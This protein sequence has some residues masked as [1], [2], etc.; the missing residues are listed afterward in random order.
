MSDNTAITGL[1]VLSPTECLSRLGT[2]GIGRVGFV[3]GGRPQVLPVNYTIVDD[4]VVFRTSQHSILTRIAG[5]PVTFEVDGFD[6]ENR[7]GW[8]VCVHGSGREVTGEA[9]LGEGSLRPSC[10][11]SWVPGPRDRWFAVV[12]VE[13]TGRRIPV[14]GESGDFGGWVPGVVS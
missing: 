2:G 11:V 10:L 14:E 9:E 4:A 12:P 3:S 8:S 13:V 5:Q 1:E 6:A 7:S